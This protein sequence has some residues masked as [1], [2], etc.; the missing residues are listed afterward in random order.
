M[1]KKS[2]ETQKQPYDIKTAVV[3][4]SEVYN[5]ESFRAI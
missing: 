1:A 3:R 5:G 2:Q 4:C